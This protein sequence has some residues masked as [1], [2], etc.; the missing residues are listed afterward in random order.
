[1]GRASQAAETARA[2]VLQLEVTRRAKARPVWPEQGRS[3]TLEKEA[4]SHLLG[5]Q[6][7]GSIGDEGGLNSRVKP[8]F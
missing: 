8:S 4:G 2:E 7:T 1:M 6:A 3:V 5:L